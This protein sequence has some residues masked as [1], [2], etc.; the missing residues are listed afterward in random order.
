MRVNGENIELKSPV[1]LGE[2]LENSGYRRERI[3]VELNGKVISKK[4]FD[5][6]TIDNTDR[7]EIVQFMG[8]G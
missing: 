6:V 5:N 4:D 7:M 2:Y 8:G 3:A 1:K